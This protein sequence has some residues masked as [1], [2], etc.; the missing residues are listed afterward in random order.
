MKVFALFLCG[1][2]GAA[3]TS[4]ALERDLSDDFK[5]RPVMKVVRLLQDTKAELEKELDD[6][7]AVY[8]MMTCWCKSGT[9]EKEAAIEAAK[10]KIAE[11]EAALGEAAA[12]MKE[13]KVKRQETLDQVNADE[14]AL[15]EASTMRMKENKEFQAS[16]TDYIEAI[17]AAKNAIIVLSKHNAAD[18]AQLKTAAR[19]LL[20]ARVSHMV[21]RSTISRSST[22][23]LRL[24]L[25]NAEQA[26][27]F[28]SIP[29]FQSYAPQSGQIYGIL[30][31]MKEDF[32]ANLSESQKAEAKAK[33]E[34][35]A[36][37]AAKEEEIAAGRKLIVDIDAQIADLQEQYA[38]EFKQ[39]EDTQEQLAMD[40]EFLKNLKEKCATMDADFEKRKKDRLAEIDAVTDTIKI[41]N[42]DASFEIFDKMKAPEPPEFLQT[43]LSASEKERKQKALSALQRAAQLSGNPQIA[44]IAASAQ[45][46]SFTKVKEMIK[47][48]VKELETQQ[49]DEI[50]HRDWC[51]KELNANNRSTEAAYD[52]KEALIAKIAD[53]EKRIE[54][55]TKD[56]AAAKEA[57]AH[58]M[59]QMK[60]ASET[61]EAEN[62]EFQTTVNDQRLMSIILTK[63]LDRMKEVYAL[64]QRRGMKPGAPH[65]QTSG[66]HTDP[67]NGP[68]AFKTYS[69]NAGGGRV[70]TMLE[71]IL[72]D[73]KE[74]IDQSMDSEQSDQSAYENFMKDSNKLIIKTTQAISD[75][76]AAKSSA[77]EELSMAKTDLSETINELEGLSNTAADLHKSCDYIL[78]NFD[79]RQAARAAEIDALNEA[80]AI[81]S[82]MK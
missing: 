35:E 78:K 40:E 71:E 26:S 51:I 12:K 28:L 37:K 3:A 48:M 49:E 13:L 22:E 61:R 30:Q 21:E 47:K 60:R 82:G 53:L 67:G 19:R 63:A 24:F 68:A 41:L 23:T 70:V 17:D 20:D 80:Y 1:L 9:E 32:E 46:D 14:K 79:A 34:Y 52:K 43:D 15:Q 10:A 77:K 33:A 62:A 56:I 27:S 6:D 11:L 72:A 59:D 25:R 81:L 29:G 58:A 2:L 8:E 18:F 7:E 16:E 45:L 5:E 39:L 38:E 36:L 31:Q 65:I 57:I 73:S 66:T 69:E 50:A 55:L 64:L 54:Q 75:M 44:L 76:T 74:V 4:A 42:N